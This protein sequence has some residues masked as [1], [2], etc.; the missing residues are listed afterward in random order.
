MN[1]FP[2]LRTLLQQA[3]FSDSVWI[4]NPDYSAS[5]K[6]QGGGY[7]VSD[8]SAVSESILSEMGSYL[9][10]IPYYHLSF[11]ELL[12]SSKFELISWDTSKVPFELVG[13]ISIGEAER[14]VATF[15]SATGSSLSQQRETAQFLSKISN[16]FEVH[17][18]LVFVT[19]VEEIGTSKLDQSKVIR[20]YLAEYDFP[21][22]DLSPSECRL[23]AFGI[24]EPGRANH[25]I[26]AY[27]V[28]LVSI[29]SVAGWIFFSYRNA[30]PSPVD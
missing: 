15:D 11:A 17:E 8:V 7:V 23:T 27:M 6:R 29:V 5:L 21:P 14:F 9:S 2:D 4:R 19:A 13:T 30:K 10:G 24:A 20:R 16:Q 12:A 28:I 18:G 25:Y 26:T 1:A 22:K 3:P